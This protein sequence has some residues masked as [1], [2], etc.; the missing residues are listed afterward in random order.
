MP[1]VRRIQLMVISLGLNGE[2]PVSFTNVPFFP[3]SS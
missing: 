1:I 3:E 2:K